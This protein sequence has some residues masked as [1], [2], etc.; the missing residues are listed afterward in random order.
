MKNQAIGDG[1]KMIVCPDQYLVDQ[2][3]DNTV[4]IWDPAHVGIPIRVTVITITPK[5]ST[6]REAA[7]WGVL[8]DARKKGI[9]PRTL[10]DKAVFEY[11]EGVADDPGFCIHFFMV[12]LGNH[13]SIFSI[14][15]AESDE[16]TDAFRSIRADLEGMIESLVERKGDAQFNCCLLESEKEQIRE[17]A[18]TVLQGHEGDEALK[19]VQI[20][21]DKAL[22]A[23]DSNGAS[24]IGLAFGEYL[25]SEVPAFHWKVKIDEYGRARSLDFAEAQ[26]SIFPEAMIQK[27]LDRKEEVDFPSLSSGTIGAVED[28][29]RRFQDEASGS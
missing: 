24:Q 28:M 15:V 19:R 3:S 8:E 29:Y 25:R 2:E 17:A 1:D 21:Y 6:E 13:H 11:R 4:V 7:Y 22:Q 20:V 5:D 27:R 18:L 10:G 16:Q 12:G 14:T 26:I 23:G 9:Q